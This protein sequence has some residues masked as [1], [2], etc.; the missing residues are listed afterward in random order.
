MFNPFEANFK[1]FQKGGHSD[2]CK[3]KKKNA[4]KISTR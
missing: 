2:H 4:I 3:V 1:F